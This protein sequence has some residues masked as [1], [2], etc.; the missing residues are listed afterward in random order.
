MW[1]EKSKVCQNVN[2]DDE[3]VRRRVCVCCLH[4]VGVSIEQNFK[5]KCVVSL[6]SYQP[7]YLDDIHSYAL[8]L[9][10]VSHSNYIGYV[11]NCPWGRE[12][13]GNY[14]RKIFTSNNIRFVEEHLHS[15]L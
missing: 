4:R 6:Y 7:M 5:P 12:P 11:P 3:N 9:L 2:P 8:Y 10:F 1:V 15:L 14:T 13:G